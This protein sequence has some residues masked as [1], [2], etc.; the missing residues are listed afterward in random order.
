MVGV[1]WKTL[2]L[3][4]SACGLSWSNILAFWKIGN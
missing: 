3:T 4:L 1:S 2:N